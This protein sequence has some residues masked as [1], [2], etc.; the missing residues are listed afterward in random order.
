VPKDF[1][2]RSPKGHGHNLA[3]DSAHLSGRRHYNQDGKGESPNGIRA[4]HFTSIGRISP[5]L[6]QTSPLQAGHE[7]KKLHI[8]TTA[9]RCRSL[10]PEGPRRKRCRLRAATYFA[11]PPAMDHTP[12]AD[13]SPSPASHCA[14]IS[15][16]RLPAPP[17]S[18]RL[19]PATNS[20]AVSY[21]RDEWHLGEVAILVTSSGSAPPDR[22]R[23]T[24][25]DRQD[26]VTAFGCLI[27]DTFGHPDRSLHGSG[28][29][30][31]RN[32]VVG[33]KPRERRGRTG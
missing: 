26:P 33:A 31:L 30:P 27:A 6:P 13:Y 20:E 21:P 28:K 18:R 23:R 32:S 7:F 4:R 24:A 25:P 8:P 15:R 16:S 1:T 29:R 5:A 17:H 22:D 10:R 3:P 12:A 2:G 14:G 9:T 19:A 11:P